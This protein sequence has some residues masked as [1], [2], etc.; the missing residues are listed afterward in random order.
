M[1]DKAG[2]RCT[3]CADPQIAD[4]TKALASGGSKRTVAVRF[5]VSDAAIQRHRANCLRMGAR[6]QKSEPPAARSRTPRKGAVQA[7]NPSLPVTPADATNRDELITKTARLVDEA[8]DLL[9]NAKAA[10][11]RRTALQA[12]KEARD[13]LALLMRVGGHLAPDNTITID[14]RRQSLVLDD[15]S[16]AELLSMESQLRTVTDNQSLPDTTD[17]N[18]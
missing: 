12:L 17:A 7:D 15:R 16:L 10:D 13:G 1:A 2:R 11:D 9:E 5:G 4:I 3:I 6:A 8:L 14:A 18:A